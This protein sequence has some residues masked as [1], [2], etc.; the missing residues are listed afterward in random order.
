MIDPGRKPTKEEFQKFYAHMKEMWDPAITV[1]KKT[2]EYYFGTAN[3]WEAVYLSNK[4][5]PPGSLPAF[6]PAFL[7]SKVDQIVSG[8]LA[9]EPTIHRRP[10]GDGQGHKDH[11]DSLEKGMQALT[12]DAFGRSTNFPVKVAAKNMVLF[13]YS[14]AVTLLNTDGMEKPEQ[15]ESESD[16]AFQ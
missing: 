15:R 3:I 11:A 1:W 10:V 13:D 6:N 8:H 7:P 2:H 16:A 14:P 5:I 9:F 12:A 4:L